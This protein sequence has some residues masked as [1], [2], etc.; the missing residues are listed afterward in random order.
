MRVFVFFF[1]FFFAWEASQDKINHDN[2]Q[3]RDKILVNRCFICKGDL[4]TADHLLLHC[5]FAR[6]LWALAWNCLGLHWVVSN[7]GRHK[8]LAWEGDAYFHMHH[9]HSS[10]STSREENDVYVGGK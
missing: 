4:A 10:S 5:P 2:L 6:T 3:K 9:F 1:F 8:L 7:T